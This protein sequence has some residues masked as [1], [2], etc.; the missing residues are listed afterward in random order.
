[1][2]IP[3]ATSQLDF[4]QNVQAVPFAGARNAEVLA[5]NI[6]RQASVVSLLLEER[7]RAN[8]LARLRADRCRSTVC[9]SWRVGSGRSCTSMTTTRRAS[10]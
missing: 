9:R 7:Q 5:Q 10:C 6:G 1:V 4:L 3:S 8:T 2:G